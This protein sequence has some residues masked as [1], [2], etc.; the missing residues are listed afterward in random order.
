MAGLREVHAPYGKSPPLPL[1]GCC[2]LANAVY[3]K[4]HG[5]S[6]GD[7]RDPESEPK[8]L[9]SGGHH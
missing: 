1:A 7:H 8:I 3:D 9:A 6:R 4:E 5:E 2:R